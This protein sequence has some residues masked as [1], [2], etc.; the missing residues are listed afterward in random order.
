MLIQDDTTVHLS[1]V[2][3]LGCSHFF[4]LL[5][6]NAAMNIYYYTFLC[7]HMFSFLLGRYVCF[8]CQHGE[9]IVPAIQSNTNLDIAMKG[10]F[11]CG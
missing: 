6:N 10:Y 1:V 8:R 2:G 4:W 3:Y 11:R 9:A 5:I 7:G